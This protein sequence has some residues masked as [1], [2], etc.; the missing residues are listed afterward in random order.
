LWHKVRPFLIC[1][2]DATPAFARDT[3]AMLRDL[4][5]LVGRN[6][7]FAAVPDWHGQWP[8]S[9]HRD[10]CS[11]IRESSS[12]ILLHGFLHER[13]RGWGPV[14]LLARGSDELNGLDAAETR[15]A[16]G[17]AQQVFTDVFG[18][19]ARG[20]LPPAW[21]RGHARPL[22]YLM[23][24]FA[25]ESRDGRRIPL[26]TFSYDCG[27]WS[28]LGHVGHAVGRLRRSTNRLPVLAIHP[29]DLHNGFWPTILR[30]TRELLDAGYHPATPHAQVA[31]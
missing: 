29:R 3:E 18:Q 10:Y 20:L 15:R 31:V 26:A 12:E 22:E 28:W 8:L 19:P 11:L 14:S 5:P 6:L 1:I 23:G 25:L 4:A 16:I 24:F 21:Q 7:S 9:G 27:R 17:H 2:H 30:L 13:R